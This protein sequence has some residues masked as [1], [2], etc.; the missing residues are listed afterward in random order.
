MDFAKF[1]SQLWQSVASDNFYFV[2]YAFA[3]CLL[4]QL[5][6]KFV[7]NKAKV[8]VMHKF[9]WAVALPF[10]FGLG[11]AVIDVFC[12]QE[13]REFSLNVLLK[14]ALSAIAIGALA[15][16]AFKF[17]KSLS[18]Q[19]L[20]ALLK[21]DVF[22]VFYTQLLYFGNIRQQ[23]ADKTLTMQD[24]LAQVKLLAS[25]AQSIYAEEGSVDQKRCRLA[26]LLKGIIDDADIDTCVN[27]INEVLAKLCQSK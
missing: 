7:V 25:N 11:F 14:I 17:V 8:D 26:Q 9:D 5:V 10:I 1:V 15:S 16:T 2:L 23:L 18:G 6:K 21:D 12:V 3:D 22:G 24:F 27:V 20:S 19:S 13:I 4:T